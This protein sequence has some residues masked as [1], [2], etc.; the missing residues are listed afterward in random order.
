MRVLIVPGAGVRRYVH[1]AAERLSGRGC[2]V[3]LCSAP[4]APGP[5]PGLRDYGAQ[6]AEGIDAACA[7][8]DLLVG[9]SFGAQAAAVAACLTR[10]GQVRRLMLI[11]PTVEPQARNLSRLLGRWVLAGRD[12]PLRLLAEQAPDWCRAGPVRLAQLLRSAAALHLEDVLPGVA[13]TLTVVHA[14]IDRITSHA[15]AARLAAERSAR[16]V[17]VPGATHSW[18]YG[19]AERFADLVEEVLR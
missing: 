8:V 12:E 14:E 10:P 4:G 19:D 17:V 3:T 13:A 18:P 9:L 15:Y 11:S 2:D 1:P 7:P 16:L 6:L 5:A